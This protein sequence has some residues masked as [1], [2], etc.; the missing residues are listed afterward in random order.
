MVDRVYQV[1]ASGIG[2]RIPCVEARTRDSSAIGM[3]GM[4]QRRAGR[5]THACAWPG[6]VRG[7]ASGAE[8]GQEDTCCVLPFGSQVSCQALEV[9][10]GLS[11]LVLHH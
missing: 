11:R 9:H 3:R 6:R 1:S 5:R 8:Q 2:C 4:P 7:G 10:D